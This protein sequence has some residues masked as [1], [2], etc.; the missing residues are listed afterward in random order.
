MIY[1]L[2]SMVLFTSIFMIF[3]AHHDTIDYRTF[4]DDALPESFDQHCIFFISDI[5]RRKI[6]LRTL[7]SIN[8]DIHM[9]VIGGDLTEK[10]VP[11]ERT[12]ENIR[13]LKQLGAPIYFVWGN[14][15]YEVSPALLSD[16]LMKENV[17]IIKD[18]YIEMCR[19]GESF[20]V[21]G[22]D[23]HK[24]FDD[25]LCIDWDNIGEGYCLLLSH[26]PQYFYD[27]DVSIQE[28]IHTVLAGHTH[29]GQIRFL[30]VGLYQR[31]GLDTLDHT[32]ILVS[33]GYGYTFLPFRLQT[34]AECHVLT[35][36]KN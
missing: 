4:Q 33:E 8:K 9:V 28:R 13:R 25:R 7:K 5:H 15:D 34:K 20:Y 17:K 21:I 12:R 2:L 24:D 36:K 16:L 29:G 3:T 14:N 22:F 31:G 6:N 10:G 11:L 32:K 18:S 27:L 26:V 35:F 30:N 23:Y 19:N 1:I